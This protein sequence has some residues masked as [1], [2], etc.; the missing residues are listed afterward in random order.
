MPTAT[1]E[2]AS[3]PWAPSGWGS[4]PTPRFSLRPRTPKRGD[5]SRDLPKAIVSQRAQ[6]PD[7][8]E[9]IAAFVIRLGERVD[10]FQDAEAAR[11]AETLHAL[12]A[13]LHD[14]AHQLGYPPLAEAAARI[15]AACEDPAP[16]ALR[17]AVLHLTELAQRVRRGHRS[18][19]G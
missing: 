9:A 2:A 15:H 17:K 6:D 5:V 18:A 10:A 13:Q 16:D 1:G 19:A 12:A 3:W 11:D 8:D 4:D 7:W 14:D